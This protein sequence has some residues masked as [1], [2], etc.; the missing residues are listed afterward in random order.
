MGEYVDVF[1]CCGC[2]G[3]GWSVVGGGLLEG[4]AVEEGQAGW[5]VGELGLLVLKVSGSFLGTW[6]GQMSLT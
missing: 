4:D 3:F 6:Y 5:F 2:Y 1:C